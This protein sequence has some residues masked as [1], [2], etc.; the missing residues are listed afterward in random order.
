MN[1]KRNEK[2]VKWKLYFL[3]YKNHVL[4][5]CFLSVKVLRWKLNK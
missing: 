4:L 2:Y 5:S 3:I 1:L